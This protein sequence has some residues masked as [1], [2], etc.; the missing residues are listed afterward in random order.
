MIFTIFFVDSKI[1]STDSDLIVMFFSHFLDDISV[2]CAIHDIT[3]IGDMI[4][5]HTLS[6]NFFIFSFEIFIGSRI[7]LDAK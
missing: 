5:C 6:E 4:S 7:F 2:S 3:V 1:F